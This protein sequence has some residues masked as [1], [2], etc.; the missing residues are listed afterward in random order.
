MLIIF[1]GNR[2]LALRAANPK[3][4]S[5]ETSRASDKN[6]TRAASSGEFVC[7]GNCHSRNVRWIILQH[8]LFA[9]QPI[10]MPKLALLSSALELK[11]K[12]SNPKCSGVGI[13]KQTYLACC[14]YFL[15]TFKG[16]VKV[17]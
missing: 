5:S 1:P 2:T 3:S 15:M 8:C 17:K 9:R 16:V 6:K 12:E 10:K 4:C 13:A 14:P 11:V 7:L